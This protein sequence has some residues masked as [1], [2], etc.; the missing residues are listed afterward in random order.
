MERSRMV[1]AT[2]PCSIVWRCPHLERNR[3]ALKRTPFA[4]AEAGAQFSAS[5]AGSAFRGDER[6]IQSETTPLVRGRLFLRLQ[7]AGARKE[8][9]AGALLAA[10][11]AVLGDS[12]V[13]AAS[14]VSS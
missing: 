4:P 6:T 3:L 14:E 8:A 11:N 12:D 5:S 10:V 2:R 7:R 1:A 13:A 9:T